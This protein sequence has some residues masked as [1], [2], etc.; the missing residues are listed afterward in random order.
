MIASLNVGQN[1]QSI[2]NNVNDCLEHDL[3]ES[4]T[5]QTIIFVMRLKTLVQFNFCVFF[6]M[7]FFVE[8]FTR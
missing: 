5:N 6:L 1:G 8:N 4:I 7:I 2:F 3:E